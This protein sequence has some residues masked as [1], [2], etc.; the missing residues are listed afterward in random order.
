MGTQFVD[1][2]VMVEDVN[3]NERRRQFLQ[4]LLYLCNIK[5]DALHLSMKWTAE[6]MKSCDVIMFDL[7]RSG[8]ESDES[9]LA[10]MR[11]ECERLTAELS[12][13]D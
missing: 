5:I 1:E 7:F 2:F 9:E 12:N 11:Q 3:G 8:L 10:K 13:Y 4:G 6:E